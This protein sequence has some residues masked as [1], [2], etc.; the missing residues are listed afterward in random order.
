MDPEGKYSDNEAYLNVPH[1]TLM[2]STILQLPNLSSDS[3]KPIKGCY[4]DNNVA[5][6]TGRK[7]AITIA[8]RLPIIMDYD[9]IFVM[10]NCGKVVKLGSP[11]ELLRLAKGEFKSMVDRQ[12]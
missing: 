12:N 3:K 6:L 4:N 7:T 10:D 1:W 9:K 5:L 11:F 8:Y 2:F